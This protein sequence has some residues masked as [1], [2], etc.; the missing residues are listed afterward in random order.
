MGV[1]E[2]GKEPFPPLLHAEQE[3]KRLKNR[4]VGVSNFDASKKRTKLLLN[5]TRAQIKKAFHDL[6]EQ[7]K[8]DEALFEEMESIFLLYYTGHG[9]SG[10]LLLADGPLSSKS[11]ANLFNLVGADFSVGV[12]DA[13]YAGSLDSV[14]QEK[15]IRA[16]RG[17][18]M[19]PDLPQDVLSAKGSIW[20][21]SS[22]AG[23]PSYEDK[24]LGGVFTHFFIEA[25]EEADK[26]GPGITLDR[27]WQYAREK[28]V[29]YTA[30][31]NRVQIPEQLVAR[32]RAKAP[33]YFS[34]PIPRDATLILS[35]KLHGKFAL[36]Y[37]NGH[38][39][40]VFEKEPG[41]R[42]EVA[43]YPGSARLMIL[44][45]PSSGTAQYEFTLAK[46]GKLVLHTMPES[47]PKPEIGQRANPLFTKGVGVESQFAATAIEPALS[48]MMGAGYGITFAD[49]EMLHPRHRFSIP[50]RLDR[51]PFILEL[52][53]TYGFDKRKYPA[54]TYKAHL[55]GAAVR[56]GYR[57]KMGGFQPSVGIGTSF[58]HIWQQFDTAG[59]EKG[60][61]Q[62][63]L[64]G[65]A[66]LVFP[67]NGVL[68]LELIGEIGPLYSPGSGIDAKSGWNIAGGIA[69]AGYFRLF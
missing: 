2:T 15:G 5:A 67:S 20:Y 60:G 21:V 13:C 34:F 49:K 24:E 63:H 69:L 35:E 18:N 52:D 44:D 3:A 45:S 59:E 23:Q 9:L 1:D 41:V 68:F 54:W 39:V 50:V 47:A 57:W 6:A 28:T 37:A 36:S 42:E 27:I 8:K 65:N 19:I 48:L 25:L 53:I 40:E 62:V 16:T 7:K 14:L 38:L 11:L 29:A 55:F 17:F 43:V 30:A 32:L 22:G 31:H 26:E 33:V 46:G 10:R 66:G 64:K 58:G 12:F 61:W 51:L 56:G 4:L